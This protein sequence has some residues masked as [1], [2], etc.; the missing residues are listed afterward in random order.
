MISFRHFYLYIPFF[1]FSL[2]SAVGSQTKTKDFDMYL[3]IGTL[4]EIILPE[5]YTTVQIPVQIIEMRDVPGRNKQ[6]ITVHPIIQQTTRT[7]I[8]I[9]S[10]HFDF[11]IRIFLN[12]KSARVTES[13][14]L[15]RLTPGP[16]PWETLANKNGAANGGTAV[17][18][19]I[20]PN[21]ATKEDFSFKNLYAIKPDLF[22][23]Q[24]QAHAIIK[25]RVVFAVDHI[26]AYKEKLVFK[27]TLWN[28]SS[29][30]YDI[31]NLNI[32]YKEKAG[33][34]LISERETKSLRLNPFHELFSKTLV[35]PGKKSHII[36]VTSKLSP[37]DTGFFNFVMVEKFGQRN[38]NFSIPSVIK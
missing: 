9:Y 3:E 16:R 15:D 13:L 7:N 12:S 11:N 34:P 32:T 23:S 33:I 30:P 19:D 18:P 17:K 10:A 36:Y 26:F 35:E 24:K 8:R 14:D 28:K 20:D 22:K 27:I 37:Q 38:F 31:L 6:V 21:V 4:S 1:L 25:N 29:I 2:N 5:P